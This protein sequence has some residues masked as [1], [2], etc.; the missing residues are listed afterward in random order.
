MNREQLYKLLHGL[1]MTE[2]YAT[3]TGKRCFQFFPTE[4]VTERFI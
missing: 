2:S 3:H 1:E 4:S